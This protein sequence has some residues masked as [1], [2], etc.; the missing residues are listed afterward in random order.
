MTTVDDLIDRLEAEAAA[1]ADPA[2]TPDVGIVMG[3]DS[4]LPV[5]E[6]AYEALDDLE[7]AEQT[8]FDEAP[9]ARFTY[10]SYVVS[11][12]R[13]PELMYAY[14]ETATARGLDVIIA[15]AG[16]KSADLP[17]MTASIAYPV[18]V[19][20]VPV[21][22]KSVDSVIGMPTGAPI[23]AVDAGKSYNAALSAAQVLAREHDE[24]EERLVELHDEQKAGV[25]DVSAD[26]HDLGLDGFRER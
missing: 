12:H 25:A 24:V 3:S 1:D 10:E 4:D 22:E 23:V 6:N 20:G 7:F 2:T 5:M 17:N 19:I 16:G 11:A 21:Q 9:D 26:L 8:D 14:G 15:G 18:P 13:T